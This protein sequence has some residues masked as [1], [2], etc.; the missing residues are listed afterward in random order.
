MSKGTYLRRKSAGLCVKCGGEIEDDRKGKVM[1]LNCT[2]KDSASKRADKAFRREIGVCP[3]CGKN[4]LMGNEKNCPECRAKNQKYH[5]EW[6][7][8][9]PGALSR[10]MEVWNMNRREARIIRKSEGKCYVCGNDLKDSDKPYKSCRCCREKYKARRVISTKSRSEYQS[11]I[12]K[13]QGLCP[14]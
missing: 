13:A 6:Y 8:N 3:R 4:K 14:H 2:A 10:N 1:C 9:H 5:D 11:S 12:W 7:E